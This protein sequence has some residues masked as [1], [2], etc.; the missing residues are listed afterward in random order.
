[1]KSLLERND[2]IYMHAIMDKMY[3]IGLSRVL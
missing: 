2:V 3:H 1:M